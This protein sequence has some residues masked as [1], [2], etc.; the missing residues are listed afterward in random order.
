MTIFAYS[1]FR[2]RSR[3]TLPPKDILLMRNCFEM[4]RIAAQGNAAKMI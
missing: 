2:I 3:N 1:F 4:E